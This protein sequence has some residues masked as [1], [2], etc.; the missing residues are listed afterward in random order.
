MSVAA[1]FGQMFLV[2]LLFAA[3]MGLI[4]LLVGRAKG[5]RAPFW[6]ATA[7]V[8][9]TFLFIAVG[10][11]YP[12]LRTLYQSFFNSTGKRFIGIENYTDVF[13]QPG[14]RI[15]LINTVI[16]VV[17][18]PTIATGIG[19]VY[20]VLVDKIRFESLAKTL[21]FLPMAISFVGAS[22]IWKF[23]YDFRGAGNTQIGLLNQILVWLHLPPQQFLLDS[24]WNTLFLIVVMIWIQAGFAMTV[25]SAAIKAIPDDINEA[26]ALDG[27]AGVRLFRYITLPSIRPALIVVLTTI[28]IGVLKVFDIVRTMTGGNFDTQVIAN[29]FYD[30]SFRFGDQGQGAA[31]AI[32]LFILVVPIVVYNVRQLRKA[33]NR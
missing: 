9:P 10:L 21:V 23:M 15:S 28:A 1:K 14:L 33:E 30:Q 25:L 4:M 6:V 5:K 8:A 7:F 32:V 17:L 22:I 24:P 20:A 26:A 3:V 16:W 2:L 12:A 19:L 13:T 29:E 31:L 27:V 18:T 11:L